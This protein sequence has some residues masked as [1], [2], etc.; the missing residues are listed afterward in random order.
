MK[1]RM[2]SMEG[3]YKKESMVTESRNQRQYRKVPVM[4]CK[5]AL[6]LY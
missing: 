4:S 3:A 6:I 2:M 5:F 1:G